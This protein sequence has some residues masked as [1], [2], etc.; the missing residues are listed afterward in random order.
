MPTQYTVPALT[1]DRAIHA[2]RA[3]RRADVA[4]WNAYARRMNAKAPAAGLVKA[5]ELA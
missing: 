4:A 5:S 3:R 2:E 1:L